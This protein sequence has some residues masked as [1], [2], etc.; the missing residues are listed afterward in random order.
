MRL[1]GC[2]AIQNKL[3]GTFSSL[4]EQHREDSP[5]RHSRRRPPALVAAK[6]NEH[7]ELFACHA[8]GT[9]CGVWT[10]GAGTGTVIMRALAPQQP[11]AAAG[12]CIAQKPEGKTL[13]DFV[14]VECGHCRRLA[15]WETQCSADTSVIRDALSGCFYWASYPIHHRGHAEFAIQYLGFGRV[16]R[17]IIRA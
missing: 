11:A 16:S 12:D 3:G 6:S 1:S 7:R 4:A 10:S 8:A 2:A 5:R 9:A 15:F 13:R 14:G 17:H